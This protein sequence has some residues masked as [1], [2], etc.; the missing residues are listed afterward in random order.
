[1]IKAQKVGLALALFRQATPQVLCS[2]YKVKALK[3]IK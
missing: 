1:M 2:N 3:I